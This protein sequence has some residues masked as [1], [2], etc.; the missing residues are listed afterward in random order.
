MSATEGTHVPQLSLPG[1]AATADGP[2][3]L[4]VMYVL[5]HAFRRDL[6]RF[7]TAARST[8][9][10]AAA[11]WAALATRWRRFAAQLHHHHRVEDRTLW[12]PLLAAV[13]AA[14]APGDRATL[15]AM[16][17][18]H[19]VIDPLLDGCARAF[20]AM[21]ERPGAAARDALVERLAEARASLG[22]HLAHE[23]T[24]ALPLLQRHLSPDAWARS[25]RVAKR[26]LGPREL[27]FLVPWAADGLDRPTREH[28]LADAGWPFRVLYRST[29][30]RYTRR[31]A[32]AFRYA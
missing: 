13:D 17:A 26:T 2:T 10:D 8:P 7:V 21:V 23:E 28:V 11:T 12:P 20:S 1:Q 14:G 3:D 5:H 18:E 30:G 19:E 16:Q 6:D 32:E 4:S 29:R 27:L 9:V 25:N 24:D 22:R 15:E 31:E